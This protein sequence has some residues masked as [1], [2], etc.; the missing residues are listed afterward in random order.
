[1]IGTKGSTVEDAAYLI[2]ALG[3]QLM[4]A[5]RLADPRATSRTSS[6]PKNSR[7]SR[8]PAVPQ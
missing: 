6:R 2:A 5:T 4:T 7:F 8:T 1:M 3:G